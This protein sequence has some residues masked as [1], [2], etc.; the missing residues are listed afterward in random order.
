VGRGK[1]EV[2]MKKVSFAVLFFLLVSCL[3][4][5]RASADIT[6]GL[7][8]YYPFN[9]NAN[10]ESGNGYD[11]TVNGATLVPDRFGKP[12]SAYSFNGSDASILLNN[13]S[14]LNFTDGF[15]LATWVHFTSSNTDKQIVAKHICGNM[16]GYFLGAG[17]LG[18]PSNVFEFYVNN[19]PRL[20]TAETY[21]DGQWHL[22]VGVYD[23]MTQYLYVDGVLTD[24]QAKTYTNSNTTNI[25]IGSATDCGY[26]SGS[27]DDVRIYNRA[28]SAAEIQELYT[29][30]SCSQTD[31][32]AAYQ[33]GFNDGKQA[34]ESNPASCGITSAGTSQCGTVT[35]DFLTPTVHI[36][37]LN[38]G[39][40]NYWLDLGIYSSS[41]TLLLD[42]TNYGTN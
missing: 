20:Y 24:S 7:V 18:G 6:T 25:T 11:G 10:D 4:I 21:N 36:P 9:G 15:T 3:I 12:N 29:G 35:T 40:T 22:V 34:C 26:F 41:P 17:T 5:G 8:A 33:Q 1:G 2:G 16:S 23:G 13:T 37:C 42:I 27:I 39:G 19:D 31:L 30:G 38:V 32:D 14:T 28:L